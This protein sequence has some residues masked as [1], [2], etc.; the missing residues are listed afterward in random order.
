MLAL[1]LSAIWLKPADE[2]CW[3][4]ARWFRGLAK[5]GAGFQAMPTPGRAFV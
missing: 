4:G 1:T 5:D 3:F 2:T